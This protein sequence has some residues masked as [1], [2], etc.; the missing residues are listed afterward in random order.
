MQA[1]NARRK[2]S[3]P[4]AIIRRRFIESSTTLTVQLHSSLVLGPYI[5]ELGEVSGLRRCS[6]ARLTIQR[7]MPK[8][9]GTLLQLT[10]HR[11]PHGNET[12]GEQVSLKVDVCR[13]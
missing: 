7:A 5:G 9:G 3:K 12:A 1:E 4:R 6:E 2:V 13:T 10:V 8:S 11:G